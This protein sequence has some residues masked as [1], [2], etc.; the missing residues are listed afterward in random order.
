MN[1]TVASQTTICSTL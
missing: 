1:C